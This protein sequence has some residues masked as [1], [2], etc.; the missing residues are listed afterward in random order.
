MTVREVNSPPVLDEIPPQT[1]DELS[2]L[3]FTATATDP[4]DPD[5]D[6]L[7]FSLGGTPPEGASINATTGTFSWTPTEQQGPGNHTATVSVS[8]GAGGTDSRDVHITVNEVN[9]P[10]TLSTPSTAVA[11]ELAEMMAFTANA[12]DPD[13]PPDDLTFS[14]D[15]PP[16]GAS[17]D[18]V[19]G[20]VRWTPTEH[21]DGV[22]EIRVVVSDGR[23]G[24]DSGSTYVIV[25]EMNEP[26]VISPIPEPAGSVLSPFSFYIRATDADVPANTLT[27]DL[28]DP[29]PGASIDPFTGL[30]S[31]APNGGGEG[32]VLVGVCGPCKP[33]AQEGRSPGR[34]T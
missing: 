29:P 1:V 14:L 18:P 2:E 23:G 28:V 15:N 13:H 20:T 30:F 21:Q 22:A 4:D 10:P 27:Y 34:E 31:W 5:G 7:S 17:I 12:T 26:P 24:S 9:S 8:D 16:E 32:P 6:G 25:V 11:F 3:T 19:T 33:N